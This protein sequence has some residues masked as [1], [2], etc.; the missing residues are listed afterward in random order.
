MLKYDKNGLK[1]DL[2]ARVETTPVNA[3]QR[4]VAIRALRDADAITDRILWV[5]NG[6]RR[7]AARAG[8]GFGKLTHSH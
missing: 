1:S 2:Y 8:V 6:M 4:E 3:I 5:V 7:L